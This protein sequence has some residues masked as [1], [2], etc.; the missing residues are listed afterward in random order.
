M[1]ATQQVTER[2]SFPRYD[3]P[4]DRRGTRYLSPA[5]GFKTGG[6]ASDKG[7]LKN[8]STPDPIDDRVLL[9]QGRPL[10]FKVL[11]Q[12]LGARK[13]IFL[14]GRIQMQRIGPRHRKIG[15]MVSVADPIGVL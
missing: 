3:D 9:F 13:R 7:E 8:F 10:C 5:K 14:L 2:A 12:G 11:V 4:F 6:R 15:K 1:P